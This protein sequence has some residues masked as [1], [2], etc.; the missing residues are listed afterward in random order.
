M[1]SHTLLGAEFFVGFACTSV[2]SVEKVWQ[3]SELV[4]EVRGSNAAGCCVSVRC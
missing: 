2:S 1:P 4:H 3:L